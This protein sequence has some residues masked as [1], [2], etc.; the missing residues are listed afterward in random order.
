MKILVYNENE[1]A[2]LV[3]GQLLKELGFS[4]IL[5]DSEF[6]WCDQWCDKV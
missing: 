2:R 5:A 4:V 1:K 3:V 6:C